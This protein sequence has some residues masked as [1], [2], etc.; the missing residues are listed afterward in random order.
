MIFL[1]LLCIILVAI[2]G[3]VF[4]DGVKQQY[5]PVDSDN[6]GVVDDRDECYKTGP[7]VNVDARG[8][9]VRVKEQKKI[10]LNINF[11]F[12][13]SVVKP[14]YYSEVKKVADFMAENPLTYVIIEGHTD[15]D[16]SNRYN[17]RLSQDRALSVVSVLTNR[18]N[19]KS[20]RVGAIGF[21]EER[22]LVVNDSEANKLKN[23]RVVAV[24]RVVTEKRG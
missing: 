1:R 21:G 22:P 10:T 20:R 3:T 6:D 19:V 15:S 14:K 2:S 16:G 9:A 7:G 17:K 23:R 18:F 24:I 12:D 8:C 4:A 5:L 11:D 13:S